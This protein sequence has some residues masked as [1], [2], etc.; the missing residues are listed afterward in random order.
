MLAVVVY[1]VNVA[2]GSHYMFLREKPAQDS[3]LDV[4]GLYP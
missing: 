1:F 2:L 3:L 4:C